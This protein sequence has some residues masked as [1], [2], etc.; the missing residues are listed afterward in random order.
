MSFLKSVIAD[1]RPAK[2]V[3]RV[4]TSPARTSGTMP[5]SPSDNVPLKSS[6]RHTDTFSSRQT[7]H[8]PIASNPPVQQSHRQSSRLNNKRDHLAVQPTRNSQPEKS[9][10]ESHQLKNV[11]RQQ[12]GHKTDESAKP[13]SLAT[14]VQSGQNISTEKTSANAVTLEGHVPSAVA[15]YPANEKKPVVSSRKNVQDKDVQ[16]KKVKPSIDIQTPI[17]AQVSESSDD[18]KVS[19]FIALT[20]ADSGQAASASNENRTT[21]K[22]FVDKNFY[23]IELKQ[24]RVDTAGS[25]PQHQSTSRDY[26][27]ELS[28]QNEQSDSPTDLYLDSEHYNVLF[29]DGNSGLQPEE[30]N[31]A[32]ISTTKTEHPEVDARLHSLELQSKQQ[33]LKQS[34]EQVIAVQTTNMLD[35][36]MANQQADLRPEMNA[37][38]LN[39]SSPEVRIGE[40]DVFI[41]K[42]T[43]KSVATGR[44][45]RPSI[46]MASRHY[47]RRL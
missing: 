29:K 19:G 1:A 28:A 45:F 27:P 36:H 8:D 44:S 4:P 14:K 35:H 15:S 18:G 30:K 43:T 33:T 38:H 16:V 26:K 23:E 25:N 13:I 20:R 6:V 34:L 2:S 46:S 22:F 37:A 9:N 39:P 24:G 5:E 11:I 7:Q 3:Q 32:D 40:V 31:A 12:T 42:P 10:S 21:P 17:Q 47:L 41:E